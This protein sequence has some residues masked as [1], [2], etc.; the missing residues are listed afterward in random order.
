MTQ[1]QQHTSYD[2]RRSKRQSRLT[3]ELVSSQDATIPAIPTSEWQDQLY[4][5]L[6]NAPASGIASPMTSYSSS[7]EPTR[8]TSWSSSSDPT[9]PML[10]MPTSLPGMSGEPSRRR[11][12]LDAPY[13]PS[14][15]QHPARMYDQRGKRLNLYHSYLLPTYW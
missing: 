8:F 11:R 5:R 4:R 9:S 6:S 12:R 2:D 15:L 1:S 14:D 3:R 10:A 13:V 7:S